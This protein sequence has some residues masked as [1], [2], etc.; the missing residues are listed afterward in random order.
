MHE[1]NKLIDV[2]NDTLRKEY[3]YFCG[4]SIKSSNKAMRDEFVAE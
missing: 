3:E 2:D 4:I 1:E